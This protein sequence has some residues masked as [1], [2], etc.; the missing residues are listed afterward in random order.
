MAG[1]DAPYLLLPRQITCK[2]KPKMKD[3]ERVLDLNSTNQSII[4]I[5]VTKCKTIIHE[6]SYYAILN[7]VD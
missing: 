7:V 5:F 3:F 2:I 6:I 1:G 4:F